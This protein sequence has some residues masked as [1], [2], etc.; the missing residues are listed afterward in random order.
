MVSND[1]STV[2]IFDNFHLLRFNYF[3]LIICLQIVHRYWERSDLRGAFVAMEKMADHGVSA[4]LKLLVLL[5]KILL[6][7][8]FVLFIY[9]LFFSFSI[10]ITI[11]YLFFCGGGRELI[12]S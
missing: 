5:V 3:S 4:C 1:L 2:N 8:V 6:L 7:T 12:A 9:I 11:Y 10:Y